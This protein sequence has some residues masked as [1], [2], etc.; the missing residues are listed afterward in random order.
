MVAIVPT[1][2]DLVALSLGV[3]RI[4][5]ISIALITP[6]RIPFELITGSREILYLRILL[7]ALL[8]VLSSSM[9][10][11]PDMTS[12]I[13]ACPKSA[14]KATSVSLTMPIIFLL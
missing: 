13:I 3:A 4:L 14:V 9:T 2:G 1:P 8:N 10:I 7:I 11:A 12:S 6:V 5:M